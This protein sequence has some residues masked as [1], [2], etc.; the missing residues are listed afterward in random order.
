MN[1]E[2]VGKR[3]GKSWRNGGAGKRRVGVEGREMEETRKGI[4]GDA[5]YCC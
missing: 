3:K 5:R 1:C 2:R 4:P